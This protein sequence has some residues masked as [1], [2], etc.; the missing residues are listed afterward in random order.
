MPVISKSIVPL[1]FIDAINLEIDKIGYDSSF[2]IFP[3]THPDIYKLIKHALAKTHFF[4]DNIINNAYIVVRCVKANLPTTAY[5]IHFDN[6]QNTWVLPLKIPHGTINGRLCAWENTRP[7]PRNAYTNLISKIIFQNPIT[8]AIIK[9]YFLD[10]FQHL[11]LSVGDCVHFNGFTSLH[12]NE[13]VKGE[14]RSI[15]IHFDKPFSSNFLT[16]A[17]EKFSQYIAN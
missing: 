1:E 2:W 3:G 6:Y 11:D 5:G 17:I 14:R 10:K 13:P 4:P 8:I 9:K 12:F 7:Q 16:S 15:L